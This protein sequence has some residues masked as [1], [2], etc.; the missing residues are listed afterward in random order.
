MPDELARAMP[1]AAPTTL[2]HHTDAG[3]LLEA[4][5]RTRKDAAAGVYT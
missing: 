1:Q 2:A 5:Q 3:Q 4:Y